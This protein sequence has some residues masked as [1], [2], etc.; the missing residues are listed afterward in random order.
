M[1]DIVGVSLADTEPRV[2]VA[3][4]LRA[5]R[6]GE[7]PAW[8]TRPRLAETGADSLR[9]LSALLDDGTAILL[10]ALRPAGAADHGSDRVGAILVD[11][12]GEP[13]GPER[14]LLS[15]EYDADANPRR[16]TLELQMDAESMPLRAAG[17]A[18]EREPGVTTL[19][20]RFEG[21]AGAATFEVV[22]P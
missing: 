15:V 5:L 6:S 20:F 2:S 17:D 18:T 22:R 11:A 13:T 19:D 8:E 14:S 3:W 10:A 21:E 7:R 12:S 9:V 4:D 1:A 16:L